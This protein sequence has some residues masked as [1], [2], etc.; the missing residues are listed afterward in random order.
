VAVKG[1]NFTSGTSPL[2]KRHVGHDN[3]HR[4]SPQREIANIPLNDV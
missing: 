2:S 3:I 4:T 1:S